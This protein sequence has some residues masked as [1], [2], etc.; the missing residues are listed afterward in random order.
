MRPPG[1]L[2]EKTARQ[3]AEQPRPAPVA[4][5]PGLCSIRPLVYRKSQAPRR[6]MPLPA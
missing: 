5:A 1:Q 2:P 6:P 3:A 4:R